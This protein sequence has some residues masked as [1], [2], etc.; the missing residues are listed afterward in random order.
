MRYS[1]IR[2][3]LAVAALTTLASLLAPAALAQDRWPSRPVKL[4]VPVPA[5]QSTDLIARLVG[6]RLGQALGQPFVVENRAGA[7][8]TIGTEAGARADPDGYTLVMATSGGMAVAP[9]LYAKLR[10]APDRDFAPISNLATVVQTMVTRPEAPFSTLAEFIAQARGG[11]MN[12]ASA[13]TGSTSHL[14]TEMFLQQ[15]KVKATHVPF[16]GAAEAQP[17]VIGG[18]IDFMLD[19]LPAVAPQIKAGRLK[20][21]G[22]SSAQRT[23][24][25]PQALTLAEQGLTG[26]EAIGWIGLAAPAGTPEP[27]LDRLNAEVRR[28]MATPEMR[29]RLQNMYFIAA[30]GSREEFARFIGQEL[31]KWRTVAKEAGIQ[32]Q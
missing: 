25:L 30:E 18:Q 3:T 7:G 15:A 32:A 11:T 13:G 6:E 1:P 21:I 10:Y 27:I 24:L 16:K 12:Y 22:L 20:V 4:I 23:P 17:Q 31:V 29:E 28:I 2:R 19:A 14:A 5:G 26:F 9:A 8:T